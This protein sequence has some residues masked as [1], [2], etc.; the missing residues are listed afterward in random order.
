MLISLCRLVLEGLL[1][2]TESGEYKLASFLDEQ[3]MN[4]LFERFIFEYYA[5][6]YSRVHVAAPQISWALDDGFGTLLPVM[7]SD[8]MLSKGDKVLI[9]DAK[10]YTHTTQTQYNV[11]TLHSANLYQIFT[12][13]K[14]EAAKPGNQQ[15]TVSGMLLYAAT[16]EAIQPDH[17]Y[18]MSGNRISVKTLDLNKEF[19]EIAAQL[20][21]I[22]EDHFSE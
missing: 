21:A 16:D 22:A 20:N 15:K 9:I 6:E 3:R 19:S 14:N 4:R 11:H 12:Y 5:K 1:L 18:Q 7:Q 2:T 17:S 10:Y 8:I 13:V